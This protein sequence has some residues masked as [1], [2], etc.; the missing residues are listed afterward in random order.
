MPL[1][2]HTP[3]FFTEFTSASTIST[4]LSE[5]G[6]TLLPRSVLSGTLQFSKKFIVSL[7]ENAEK[8]EYK[9]LG[10]CG[11]FAIRVSISQLLVT[12]HLPLPVIITFLA[13]RSFFSSKMI[14]MLSSEFTAALCAAIS[15]AAPAPII[16]T[17][18][19]HTTPLKSVTIPNYFTTIYAKSK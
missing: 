4:A 3:A 16:T 10:F 8:A 18:F 1:F 6:N 2:I 5:T 19:K 9:N 14:F 15:P 13:G 7:L 12:L 17:C 11:I